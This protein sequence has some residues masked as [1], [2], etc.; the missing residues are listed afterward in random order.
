MSHEGP[1]NRIQIDGMLLDSEPRRTD[2]WLAAWT[3]SSMRAVKDRATDQRIDRVRRARRWSVRCWK[4]GLVVDGFVARFMGLLNGF[5]G[6]RR[7]IAKS[8]RFVARFWGA[9]NW[10]VATYFRMASRVPLPSPMF[11]GNCVYPVVRPGSGDGSLGVLYDVLK[12]GP[13]PGQALVCALEVLRAGWEDQSAPLF[14]EEGR[15][16]AGHILAICRARIR[17]QL[18]EFEVWSN[19]C[20]LNMSEEDKCHRT[21]PWN[22]SKLYTHGFFEMKHGNRV[23]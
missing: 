13:T 19:I 11:G 12:L 2:L 18:Q 22:I 15:G 8:M 6:L 1:E 10:S 14:P 3:I 4:E 23:H 17:L 9:T 7:L 21:F 5:T 20:I 16:A